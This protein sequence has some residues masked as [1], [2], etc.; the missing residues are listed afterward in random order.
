VTK[1]SNTKQMPTKPGNIS[2]QRSQWTAAPQIHPNPQPE[3]I[4]GR[5]ALETH[6]APAA[7]RE[8]HSEI[9]PNISARPTGYGSCSKAVQS[10]EIATP[11]ASGPRP[12]S[13]PQTIQVTIGRV[14]IRATHPP[15][16]PQKR[17]S[18]SPALSLEAYLERRNKGGSR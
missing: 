11:P 8:Q 3:P 16:R 1:E 2:R 10:A 15:P 14:E 5:A 7:P 6:I 17:P 4:N 18:P 13:P 12:P 9:E